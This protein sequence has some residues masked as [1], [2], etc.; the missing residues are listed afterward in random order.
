MS[1]DFDPNAIY[2]QLDD[3]ELAALVVDLKEQASNLRQTIWRAEDEIRN[4]L[5]ERSAKRIQ[6]DRYLI[7]SSV[8]RDIKWNDA[9]LDLTAKV[10]EQEGVKHLFDRAFPL[11][12][13][14][15]IR[16]LNEL[17][18][19]GGETAKSIELSKSEVNEKIELA[20]EVV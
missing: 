11:V 3:D 18:K 8:K 4:R 7:K 5:L 2:K 12:Y 15:K 19:F 1:V 13:S 17:L 6:G 9:S 16:E 14:P 20:Y 10:A